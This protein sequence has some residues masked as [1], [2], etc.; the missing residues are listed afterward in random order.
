M[1][2]QLDRLIMGA[3]KASEA[4]STRRAPRR[5]ASSRPSSH[6]PAFSRSN[7][8]RS[9]QDGGTVVNQPPNSG[10]KIHDCYVVLE[11]ISDAPKKEAQNVSEKQTPNDERQRMALRMRHKQSGSQEKELL[12]TS[13]AKNVHEATTVGV[14]KTDSGAKDIKEHKDPIDPDRLKTD[15]QAPGSGY[16]RGPFHQETILNGMY[17]AAQRGR[18]EF[19]VC[20]KNFLN[21]AGVSLT[22]NKSE[23]MPLPW[24]NVKENFQED[25]VIS[26]NHNNNFCLF[27]DL[28]AEA[29]DE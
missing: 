2:E 6:Q 7:R 20:M 27:A 22:T 28:E 29:D 8:S 18:E 24:F 17:Q 10:S 11:R 9:F 26:K 4:R 12:S 19:D 5:D 23:A 1:A 25:C 21:C 15:C 14:S 3:K 16:I 13:N